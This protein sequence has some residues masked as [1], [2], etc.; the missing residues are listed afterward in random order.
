MQQFDIKVFHDLILLMTIIYIEYT[1]DSARHSRFGVQNMYV[2]C[3]LRRHA[4]V[5]K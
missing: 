2:A 3:L 5:T 1:I 4:H